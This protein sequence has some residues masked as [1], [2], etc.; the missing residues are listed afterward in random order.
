MPHGRPR[1]WGPA[2]LQAATGTLGATRPSELARGASST[3]GFVAG[4]APGDSD[5]LLAAYRRLRRHPRPRRDHDGPLLI[6]HVRQAGR[7]GLAFHPPS[8]IRLYLKKPAQLQQHRSLLRLGHALS[9]TELA[10]EKSAEPLLI[11]LSAGRQLDDPPMS[12]RRRWQST[13]PPTPV[14][15]CSQRAQTDDQSS[16]G[17]PYSRRMRYADS[18]AR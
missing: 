7:A 12:W 17:L 14:T 18:G 13:A 4:S 5:R 10:I 16:A 6:C 1:R 11:P 3:A 9:V 2:P 8:E 15:L